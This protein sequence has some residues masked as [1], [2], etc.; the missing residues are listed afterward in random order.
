LEPAASSKPSVI[1]CRTSANCF[2]GRGGL[3]G[4]MFGSSACVMAFHSLLE[5]GLPATTDWT[6]PAAFQHAGV[7]S[8]VQIAFAFVGVMAIGAISL[9]QRQDVFVVG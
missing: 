6:G 9:D 7:G 5:S 2:S 3:F 4:G 8:E 1:H